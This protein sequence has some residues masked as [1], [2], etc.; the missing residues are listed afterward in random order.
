MEIL[1]QLPHVAVLSLQAMNAFGLQ[2]K[3]AASWKSPDSLPMGA[4]EIV[5]RPSVSGESAYQQLWCARA[6][7]HPKARPSAAAAAVPMGTMVF[8]KVLC[9]VLHVPFG[10]SAKTRVFAVAAKP[11]ITRSADV[12]KRLVIETSLANF[13]GRLDRTARSTRTNS[14]LKPRN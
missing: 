11:V 9:A 2:A 14:S 1:A 10:T 5:R 13:T 12:Y 8:A 4:A 3:N 7:P 6:F